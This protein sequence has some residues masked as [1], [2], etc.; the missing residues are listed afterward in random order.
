MQMLILRKLGKRF[1][2]FHSSALIDALVSKD[3]SVQLLRYIFAT[4]YKSYFRCY[5]EVVHMEIQLFRIYVTNVNT[6]EGV[7]NTAVRRNSFVR[8]TFQ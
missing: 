8:I 7:H 4:E 1:C 3:H 6:L 5:V 2:S